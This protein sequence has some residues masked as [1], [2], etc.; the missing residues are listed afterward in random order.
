[1][2]TKMDNELQ[3][4]VDLLDQTLSSEV[5]DEEMNNDLRVDDFDNSPSSSSSSFA[6]A[7]SSSSSS[8]SSTTATN[9]PT[10]TKQF[11]TARFIRRRIETELTATSTIFKSIQIADH[12]LPSSI[13]YEIYSY[14]EQE[15]VY[16]L[17]T[18]S[19]GVRSQLRS[20]LHRS[21]SLPD[22]TLDS[23]KDLRKVAVVLNLYKNYA[24]SLH[25]L[26]EILCVCS[27]ANALLDRLRLDEK[28]IKDKNAS[29]LRELTVSIG[30]G[31]VPFQ[32]QEY[33]NLRS[34]TLCT[35][36]ELTG[37][38]KIREDCTAIATACR[39]LAK[40]TIVPMNTCSD[41]GFLPFLTAGIEKIKLILGLS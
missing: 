22:L 28:E 39:H 20:F 23:K 41:S 19:K 34:I 5:N 15:E 4:F 27:V 13:E 9:Q 1:M 14:S 16:S 30:Y 10:K 29:N 17:S 8:S 32:A 2:D 26:P 18:V 12:D 33:R 7:V 6:S 35:F 3:A 36:S 24:R 21:H 38:A 11:H 25:K 40:I 37:R 31:Q